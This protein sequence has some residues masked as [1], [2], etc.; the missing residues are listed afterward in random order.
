MVHPMIFYTYYSPCEVAGPKVVIISDPIKPDPTR[1]IVNIKV[2]HSPTLHVHIMCILSYTFFPIILYI[3][4]SLI[5]TVFQ[6]HI[7]TIHSISNSMD[8]SPSVSLSN[9]G[10]FLLIGLISC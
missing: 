4:T 9:Q 6:S 10:F 5:Y 8:T 2:N 1:H 7:H 3:Y